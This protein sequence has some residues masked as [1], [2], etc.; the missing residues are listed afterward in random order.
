MHKK[1]IIFSLVVILSLFVT[2]PGEVVA[3]DREGGKINLPLPYG[4]T[5]GTLEPAQTMRIQDMISIGQ[6]FDRLVKID[7]ET[8]EPVPAVAESWDVSEDGRIYTFHL[9]DDVKFHNG[10]QLTAHDVK[11]T[12]ER[13]M[14]PAEAADQAD[15]FDSIE[16]VDEYQD[17]EADEIR[18]IEVIDDFTVEI[19]LKSLDI[20]FIYDIAHRGASI[21]PAEAVKEQGDEF[22]VN[23]IGSGPFEFEEWIRGSEIN[24]SAFDDYYDGRPY[25]DEVSFKVMPESASRAASFR[26]GEL[27][28]DV[29][30]PAQY[31]AFSEDPE[32][33][34][35]IIDIPELW[36]RNVHFNL[37]VVEETE[38]RKAF[39][40][41][42]DEELIIERLLHGLAYEPVGWLPPTSPGFN[43]D[44]EGFG[45]DPDKAR[46]L[47]EEAG[48]GPDNP[49]EIH[50]MGTDNPSWGV[51]IL[52]AIQPMLE[53]VGI[54]IEIEL[55]D[56]ATWLDRVST[57]DFEASIHSWGGEVLPSSYM[58]SYF[59]SGYSRAAGNYVGYDNPEF[60]ENIEKARETPELEE[61]IEYI[62]AA[63]KVLME[64][65]PVWFFNYNRATAVHQPHVKGIVPNPKE[66]MYIHLENVWLEE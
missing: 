18:G 36:T 26:A 37:D 57:G 39:N 34:D 9:R 2:L 49:Y 1:L 47:M 28:V 29:L 16:G 48:Y 38:V 17:E 6:I 22:F 13:V 8:L 63:E 10:E 32:Y 44:L 62:H 65:P 35:Y 52:E 51:R 42:I 15:L 19:K 3:E 30:E 64:D 4:G 56:G 50:T 54:E 66:M 46:E 55:V 31:E 58:A 61:R 7:P 45:H 24:L 43:P 23:P 27:D 14:D 11:F 12:I 59:Y 60:D 5:V 40:Y 20:E 33:Q 53:D 21:L 25:L 41:A